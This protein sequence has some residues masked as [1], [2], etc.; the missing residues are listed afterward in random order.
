MEI[1]AIIVDQVLKSFKEIKG[2]IL[3]AFLVLTFILSFLA[4]EPLFP[5]AK[6]TALLKE[7][8]GSYYLF[9]T[10]WIAPFASLAFV[11][12]MLLSCFQLLTGQSISNNKPLSRLALFLSLVASNLGCLYYGTLVSYSPNIPISFNTIKAINGFT[13][14][15]TAIPTFLY[16]VIAFIF[17][18]YLAATPSTKTRAVG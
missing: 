13:Q 18:I 11:L 10:K 8:I 9:A 3:P 17:L 1:L 14:F 2:W 16:T 7:Y 6:E 4:N 5:H 15:T 12:S